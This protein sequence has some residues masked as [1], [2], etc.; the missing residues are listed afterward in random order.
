MGGPMSRIALA[1]VIFSLVACTGAGDGDDADDDDDDSVAVCGNGT[2]QSGESAASCPADCDSGP[3]CGDGACNGTET[4]ASCAVDCPAANEECGDETCDATETTASCPSDCPCEGNVVGDDTCTGENV[5]VNG[6]CVAAFGRVYRIVI[7][8][9]SMMQYNAAGDTWD[10]PGGL[11]DPLVTVT[12]N[13]N[14]LG[15]TGASQ[16]TLTPSWGEDFSS[17]IPGGSTIVLIVD[18][19]D[20]AV[21]DYMFGCALS[22]I[23]AAHLRSYDISCPSF[24]DQPAGIGSSVFFWFE[25]Q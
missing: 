6:A 24:A 12:L 11:P 20:V 22:P 21:D 18:D 25:P 19:E 2:C 16:D 9:G 8:G 1:A 14:D 5:C 4:T 17:V 10:D 23:T 15:S 3:A 7:G 13:D